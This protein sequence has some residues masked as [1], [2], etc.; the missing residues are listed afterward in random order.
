[1]KD[2]YLDANAHVPMSIRTLKFFS[3]F[4]NSR[5]AHGHPSSP[6]TPGREASSA[7]E[8]ARCKIASLLGAKSPNQIFFTTSCTQ[9]C[10]W[11]MKIIK[12]NSLYSYVSRLE[13]PAVSRAADTH[14]PHH[15]L[16]T[17]PSGVLDLKKYNAIPIPGAA[18]SCIHVQN[19]IGTIQPIEKIRSKYPKALIFSDMSQ[20]IG[21]VPIDLQELGVDFAT[22]GAHKFGGPS[23]VG[24]MYLKNTSYWSAFGTGSRYYMD[25]PGTPNVAGI[26]TTAVALQEA[27]ETLPDRNDKMLSFQRTLELGLEGLGYEIIGKGKNRVLNT[28][29]AKVPAKKD[30]FDAG[31]MLQMKL[32]QKGIHIGLGSACGSMHTG[33]SPLMEALGRPSEGQEYI[34]ISHWGEYDSSDAERVLSNIVEIS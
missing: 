30:F 2:L 3:E 34:R 31:L 1:M 6:S 26:A 4:N 12:N 14:L 8:N 7:I 21:K 28:T 15:K 13:H 33:G 27:L 20:S 25:A 18:I 17:S 16:E 24:F 32:T 9:A 5:A 19:E 29:F 23:G 22:F 11:V 10:E